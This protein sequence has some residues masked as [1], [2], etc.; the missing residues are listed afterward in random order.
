[1]ADTH[2]KDQ[3]HDGDF[4]CER[5]HAPSHPQSLV[6]KIF[7]GLITS[8]KVLALGSLGIDC[9]VAQ[10]MPSSEIGTMVAGYATLAFIQATIQTLDKQEILEI[11]G[12]APGT[13]T[14]HMA[15]KFMECLLPF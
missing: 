7:N 2:E 14:K 8:C 1:M 6:A 13:Y 5:E 3:G 4:T 15:G 12:R 10:P 9:S 11:Q